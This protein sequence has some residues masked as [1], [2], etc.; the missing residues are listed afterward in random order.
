MN[1]EIFTKTYGETHVVHVKTDRIFPKLL[2]SSLSNVMTPAL[3][4]QAK[5]C[6][7]VEVQKLRFKI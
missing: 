5:I 7:I 3:A 2:N 1:S 4:C 6:N